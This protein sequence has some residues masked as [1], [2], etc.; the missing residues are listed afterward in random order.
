MVAHYL[1]DPESRHNMD[2]LAENYLNYSPVSITELIGKKGKNQGNM[3]D[4]EVAEIAEYAAEDADITFQLKQVLDPILR[5]TNQ[6]KLF[7]EVEM[8][9]I[10]VLADME[11]MGV[12][13]DNDNLGELSKRA[14]NREC[15]DREAHL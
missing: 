14:G 11:Y 5:E 1:I 4:V 9:L 2:I 10:P 6:T 13:V 7:E 8:K 12:R 15:G 3:R